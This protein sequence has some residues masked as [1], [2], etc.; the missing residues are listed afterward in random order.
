MIWIYI[1]W[2]VSFVFAL[3][4]GIAYRNILGSLQEFKDKIEQFMIP[5]QPRS[6]K[7]SPKTV[8]V[9]PTDLEQQVKMEQEEML[10]KLNPEMYEEDDDM[11]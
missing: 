8:I 7:P 2:P 3:S 1:F 5:K 4:V 6:T 10:R 9:D 11:P